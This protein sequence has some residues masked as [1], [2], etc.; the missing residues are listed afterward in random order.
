MMTH[1]V[2]LWL[3]PIL[4]F[5]RVRCFLCLSLGCEYKFVSGQIH[6][7]RSGRSAEMRTDCT[8][9]RHSI[10][11]IDYKFWNSFYFG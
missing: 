11:L 9:Q 6:I 5:I 4:F 10:V 1:R 2:C 7:D 8:L 3:C